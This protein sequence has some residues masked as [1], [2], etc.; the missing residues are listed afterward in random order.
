M[1]EFKR[2]IGEVALLL[3]KGEASPVEAA[4]AAIKMGSV[5]HRAAQHKIDEDG[6][7]GTWKEYFYEP[8]FA[9]LASKAN[10]LTS[11]VKIT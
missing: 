3:A 5:V 9:R 10:T 8:P 7:R 4:R 11:S 2:T 6:V 1:D